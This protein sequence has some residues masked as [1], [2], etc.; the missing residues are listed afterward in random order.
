MA[1]A[2]RYTCTHCDTSITAWSDGNPYYLDGQGKKQYAY[3]PDHE[4]LARC[5]GNDTPNL[6]LGCGHEFMVD[7]E[8]PAD[9][10]PRCRGDRFKPTFELEGERC[11]TCPEGRFSS[12]PDF[13][14]IS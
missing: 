3:H 2:I 4:A 14:V 5:I 7:S 10:C 13:H 9:A 6:C 8:A 11:P 1:Q 12:D